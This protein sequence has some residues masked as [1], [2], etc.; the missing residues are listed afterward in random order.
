MMKLFDEFKDRFTSKVLNFTVDGQYA[1]EVIDMLSESTYTQSIFSKGNKPREF[2][3]KV[4]SDNEKCIYNMS[5]EMTDN[6]WTELLRKCDDKKYQL[7]IKKDHDQMCFTK[8]E[9]K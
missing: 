9:S 5:I 3:L 6:E 8:I 4:D 2:R 7:I 1:K